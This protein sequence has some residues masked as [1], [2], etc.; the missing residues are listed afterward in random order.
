LKRRLHRQ[1]HFHVSAVYRF[2]PKFANY[3]FGYTYP[4]LHGLLSFFK[5]ENVGLYNYHAVCE[6]APP[7]EILGVNRFS[8]DDDND[9]DKYKTKKTVGLQSNATKK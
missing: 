5:S 4:R 8:L 7:F 3:I 9:C 1:T 6:C 2:V